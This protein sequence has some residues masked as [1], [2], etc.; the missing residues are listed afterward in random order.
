MSDRTDALLPEL[1]DA[2]RAQRSALEEGD[3]DKALALLPKR[4]GIIREIQ[5][6]GGPVVA[7][8]SGG[9]FEDAKAARQDDS[10]EYR[11]STLEQILA[12]DRD[13]TAMIR[14]Q[15]S[16]IAS[17]LDDVDKVKRFFRNA[18]SPLGGDDGVVA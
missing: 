8:R 3:T 14:H 11:R 18:A 10:L 2:V 6:N 13:I 16:A 15:M 1:L 17:R 12:L 4:H 7:K 9:H 5:N